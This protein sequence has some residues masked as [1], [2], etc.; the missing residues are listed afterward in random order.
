M[1]EMLAWLLILLTTAAAPPATTPSPASMTDAEALPATKAFERWLE[2]TLGVARGQHDVLVASIEPDAVVVTFSAGS[3]NPMSP[4]GGVARLR[5]S[6]SG[7]SVDRIYLEGPDLWVYPEAYVHDF[8]RRRAQRTMGEM[9][10]LATAVE[11][12]SIDNNQYPVGASPT[13]LEMALEPTYIG[14]VP[15]RDGWGS[16]F[17]YVAEPSEYCVVSLG[18]GGEPDVPTPRDVHVLSKG[19]GASNDISRDIVFCTGSFVSWYE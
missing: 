2:G 14:R 10:T 12:Y 7:W 8:Q 19:A 4:T 18:A 5:R 13:D 3:A 11:S 1:T 6:G 9:R 16:P 15:E 17:L